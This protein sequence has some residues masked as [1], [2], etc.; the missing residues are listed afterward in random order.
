MNN[1]NETLKAVRGKLD[2]FTC[3]IEQMQRDND[4][5][6]ESI[7]KLEKEQKEGY[8]KFNTETHVLIEKNKLENI[9]EALEDAYCSADS[10]V[11]NCRNIDTYYIEETESNAEQARDEIDS[12]REALEALIG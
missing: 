10:S 12:A 4:T 1:L 6:T 7:Q 8:K 2:F 9:L 11:D 3:E 5:L